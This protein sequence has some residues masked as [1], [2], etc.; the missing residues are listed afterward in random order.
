MPTWAIVLT[1]IFSGV[2]ALISVVS[3]LRSF[4][5]ATKDDMTE[6]KEDLKEDIK[7]LR[8]EIKSINTRIDNHLENHSKII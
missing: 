6:F 7:N 5:F 8:D 3:F 2:V 4:R 1:V